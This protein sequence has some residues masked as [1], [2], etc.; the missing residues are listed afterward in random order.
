MATAVRLKR[1][2]EWLTKLLVAPRTLS[3]RVRRKLIGEERAYLELSERAARWPGIRGERMR[4]AL[5]RQ[6][7]TSLG[8][9]VVL[10]FG[11]VLRRPPISIGSYT[12][13]GHYSSVQ[14]ARIGAECVIA[15]YVVIVDGARQHHFD[16]L[17]VP[18]WQQGGAYDEQLVIG[19]D[20]LI[21]SG[22][23][24]LAGLG[25][26]CVVGAGSVVTRPVA[27]YKVVAGNPA[28]EISDRRERAA[29]RAG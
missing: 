27:P 2:F 11:C 5:H 20:C 14:H 6:L 28:R 9:G 17:D 15:D 13:I 10:R 3:Y 8:V 25:D 4:Q 7:G 19:D 23:V 1:A 18:I 12:I 26:H 22:A 16:R 29:R 21:G 24:I